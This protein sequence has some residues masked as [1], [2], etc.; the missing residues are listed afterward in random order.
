MAELLATSADGVPVTALD[1]GEGPPVLLVHG[2]GE[3]ATA[4]DAVLPSLTDAFRVVRV[5]RRIYVPGAAVAPTHSMSVEAAD[6]LAVAGL[7]DRPVLLVGHSSGAV[8]ALEAA[9]RA[10]GRLAGLV[11][12]EPPLPTRAL[13]GGE[14]ARRAREA[15]AAGDPRE[16]LRIHLRDIAHEPPERVGRLTAA[17]RARDTFASKVAAGL[18]DI[19]ALDGLGVGVDRFRGL[20]VPTTLV[21]G[22]RSPARLRERL[23]DLAAALPDARVVTLPG[24]GHD[25]HRTAPGTLAAVIR[26]AAGRAFGRGLREQGPGA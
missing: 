7:L 12:Y 10:P 14:A 11:L 20:H 26:E 17:Q 5:V 19:A 18:A 25:T 6:V 24:Q 4:W 9:V 21:E 2:G 8:A 3:S 22:D 23:A 13:V 15:L 16:A 1:D